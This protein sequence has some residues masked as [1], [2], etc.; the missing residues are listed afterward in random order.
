MLSYMH[1]I[2]KSV[3]FCIHQKLDQA[4]GN[5]FVSEYVGD[6]NFSSSYLVLDIVMLD[7]DMFCLRVEDK[8]MSKSNESLIVSS[9]K[10][11]I[12]NEIW[13]FSL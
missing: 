6:V 9:Q 7:I 10:D 3:K 5:H 11:C 8:V 12:G 2:Q 1:L 13:S 4:I